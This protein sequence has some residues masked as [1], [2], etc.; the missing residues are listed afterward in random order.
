M[1][2]WVAGTIAI[3]LLVGSPAFAKGKAEHVVVIVWDG[4]RPDFVN[5]T[6]TPTLAKLARTGVVFANHH[7]V[8]IS[9]TEV[10]GAALATGMYPNRN[11]VIANRE[12]RPAIDPLRR[13]EIE[14]MDT[15]VKG[16]KASG[17]HYMRAPTLP[18]ILRRAGR[19]VAI[20][21]T[22]PVAMLFDR[23]NP[24]H[25]KLSD[26]PKFDAPNT[27]VDAATTQALIGSLWDA[28]VPV[29]SLLWLSDPDATQHATWPGAD[30]ALQAMKSVDA[31]LALVLSELAVKGV[32][33]KTDVFVV[34][35]HGFSTVMRTVDVA[36]AL[37]EAGFQAAREY[38]Q[39]PRQGDVVVVGNGGS[40]LLYVVR[41][42]RVLTRKLVEFLQQQDFTGVIMTREPMPGTFTL[43]QVRL[44]SPDAP[45]IVLSMR[46]TDEKNEAGVA[47]MIVSDGAAYGKMT[48]GNAHGGHSSLSPFDIHNTLVVT[49]PDFRSGLVDPFPS[50]NADLVPTILHVLGVPPPEPMDGRVLAEAF[51][52]VPGKLTP[53]ETHRLDN[54]RDGGQFMWQQYLAFS[55]FGGAIYLDGGN[56]FSQ[57]IHNGAK[58]ASP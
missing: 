48:V 16:D 7:C 52:V 41:R 23:S 51:T 5:E 6:N 43:E 34:S 45:D 46:W 53:V 42:D 9:S 35:D 17:G 22:K 8:Y 14:A 33:D 11:G 2:T 39:P 10:N 32:R 36:D 3:L 29:F 24:E 15:M 31:D 38:Q 37:R 54:S 56:G 26:A 49:G 20:A 47:G 21:G 40:V 57:V 13:V 30:K 25:V 27:R 55:E 58:A 18:E 50:G 19:T 4:M 12:Y 44:N 28:G 1:K